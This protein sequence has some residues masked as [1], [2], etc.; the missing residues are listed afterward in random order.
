MEKV[1]TSPVL[2]V[3]PSGTGGCRP[4]P[5]ARMALVDRYDMAD[6]R[7]PADRTEKRAPLEPIEKA[8]RNEPMDPIEQTDPMDPIDRMD[9]LD[10]TER[11]EF[12]DHND[13]RDGDGLTSG[14]M[15]SCR[16]APWARDAKA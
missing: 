5:V 15:P 16:A 14:T 4:E 11:T 10:P 2:T 3:I 6:H 7:D 12:S 8:D 9:P 13:Q 1:S